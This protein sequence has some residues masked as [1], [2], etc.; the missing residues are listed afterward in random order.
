MLIFFQLYTI[1][2]FVSPPGRDTSGGKNGVPGVKT[3]VRG[4]K[5][6]GP[7]KV[8]RGPSTVPSQFWFWTAF[9]V[10]LVCIGLSVI[11]KGCW[12]SVCVCWAFLSNKE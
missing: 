10:T 1:G 4:R 7:L 8:R 6:F 12:G 11:G 5:G 3:T 2:G 9:L